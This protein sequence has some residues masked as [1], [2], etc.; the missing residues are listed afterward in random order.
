M[1]RQLPD[2]ERADLMAV[3]GVVEAGTTAAVVVVVELVA[4]EEVL[5]V[6]LLLTDDGMDVLVFDAVTAAVEVVA[7]VDV[8]LAAT[9]DATA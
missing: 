2:E 4:T 8:T 6:M 7:A 9:D 5:A 1:K 3:D